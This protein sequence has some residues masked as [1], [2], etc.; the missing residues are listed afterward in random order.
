MSKLHRH[1]IDQLKNR[2][3]LQNMGISATDT[4]RLVRLCVSL[5]FDP[6]TLLLL[7]T[8]C[9]L[10]R[11]FRSV[12]LDARIS[13]GSEVR[14]LGQFWVAFIVGRH[15]LD[16]VAVQ[17]VENIAPKIR[18]N[19]LGLVTSGRKSVDFV[20]HYEIAQGSA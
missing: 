16:T 1:N 20:G 3:L 9:Q 4:S 13:Y 14:N 8:R 12:L 15:D 6:A 11:H 17:N 10:E 7:R 18:K 2:P 19:T 5:I